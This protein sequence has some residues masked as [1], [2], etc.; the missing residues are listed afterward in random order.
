MS[1]P[2]PYAVIAPPTV[3]TWTQRTAS[4][5][6]S[7]S[8]KIFEPTGVYT[9]YYNSGLLGYTNT[10]PLA[11]VP[12]GMTLLTQ[13]GWSIDVNSPEGGYG[14]SHYYFPVRF[15]KSGI[16]GR[17]TQNGV[18][19]SGITVKL[20]LQGTVGVPVYKGA[21]TTNSDGIY[22]F[23]SAASLTAG[24][25]YYVMYSNTTNTSRLWTWYTDYI[26]VYTAGQRAYAGNFDIANVSLVSPN[27]GSIFSPYTFTWVTR[28][29]QPTETYFVEFMNS[30]YTLYASVDSIGHAS[31]LSINSVPSGF[32]TNVSYGWDIGI[33]GT[34]G[35]IG[36]SYQTF[37][38]MFK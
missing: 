18:N 6:D 35:G 11:A 16:Q 7:Y 17:V 10:K 12:A 21:T 26:T 9:S 23:I 38:F 31:G 37:A 1:A 30:N 8:M 5:S 15:G 29:A 22:Q 28:R 25:K 14:L 13:Y 20:Y 4:P 24:Q 34:D 36:I 2:A 3:F 32:S 33:Y 19:I 27:G